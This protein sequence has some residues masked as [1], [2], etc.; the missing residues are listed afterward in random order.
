[1]SDEALVAA[2]AVG[3]SAALGALFDRHHK[4]VH[5]FICRVAAVG[6]IDAEDLLQDTFARVWSAS[7]RFKGDSTALTWIFGIA[8]HV[9]QNHA[10]RRARGVH[11]MLALSEQPEPATERADD[12]A[13]RHQALRRM[14]AALTSLRHDQRVVFVMCDLEGVPGVEAARALGVRPG[15][16]WRWLHE[17]RLALREAA[18]GVAP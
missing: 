13:A 3:E 6:A 2:C 16:V 4:R 11:A 1:M 7:P 10:R 12:V 15:T 5:R 18:G 8:A 17:A 9:A 14:Q